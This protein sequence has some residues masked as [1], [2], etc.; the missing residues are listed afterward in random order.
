LFLLDEDWHTAAATYDLPTGT[1]QTNAGFTGDAGA[2]AAGC[3]AP[4]WNG[5]VAL[6]QYLL[7]AGLVTVTPEPLAWKPFPALVDLPTDLNLLFTPCGDT[8]LALGVPSDPEFDGDTDYVFRVD[9]VTQTWSE[10]VPV[11]QA[12]LDRRTPALLATIGNRILIWGG[13]LSMTDLPDLA[14][15]VRNDGVAF[16]PAS[17][18]WTPMTCVGAPPAPHAFSQVVATA[19]GFVVLEGNADGSGLA[20]S[21]LFEL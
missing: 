19:S 1:W 5:Q 10:L 7:S 12:G 11:P 21:A 2:V 8:Y 20:G 3:F 16:D 6:C 18:T 14:G 9:P 15:Q 4:A 17:G 13:A